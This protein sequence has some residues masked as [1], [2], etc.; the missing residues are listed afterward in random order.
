MPVP[1]VVF[2][3]TL[4]SKNLQHCEPRRLEQLT[5]YLNNSH[6]QVFIY[7]INKTNDFN[8]KIFTALEKIGVRYQQFFVFLQGQALTLF[9]KMSNDRFLKSKVGL[10]QNK[11]PVIVLGATVSTVTDWMQEAHFTFLDWSPTSHQSLE[12]LIQEQLR[13]KDDAETIFP[14]NATLK[15]LAKST[16]HFFSAHKLNKRADIA[17]AIPPHCEAE[18]QALVKYL[19]VFKFDLLK[20]E[21]TQI[22]LIE[23]LDGH[24]WI[25]ITHITISLVLLA[26]HAK[27]IGAAC[28]KFGSWAAV[29]W[30]HVNHLFSQNRASTN[31]VHA[32][33][34][35]ENEH[36]PLVNSVQR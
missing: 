19:D 8:I 25:G 16:P 33:G 5:P 1:L 18:F 26:L 29:G 12:Q 4:L 32:L 22:N 21:G 28:N 35:K 7:S 30:R 23:D 20:A 11:D 27:E 6:Y 36:I 14:V 9:E 15:P 34:D 24:K 2:L 13:L 17:I 31:K 3:E 10:I